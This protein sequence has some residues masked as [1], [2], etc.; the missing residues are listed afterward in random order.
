[1]T[2]PLFLRAFPLIFLGGSLLW[3]GSSK[4][5]GG[6]RIHLQIAGEIQRTSQSAT[7]VL[8]DPEEVITVSVI[9]NLS[10][11][12]VAS[13]EPLQNGESMGMIVTFNQLGKTLL[14]NLTLEGQ[15]RVMVIYLNDRIVYS[16]IIDSV[17]GNGVLVIPSG[18]TPK[19]LEML[20]SLVKKL[21]S[22]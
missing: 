15:G 17:I 22:R 2:F 19:D 7:V 5:S 21:K 11:T 14:N 8:E 20:Q 10:E 16:P 6:L 1:M 9:P 13:V 12:H 4:P 18:V 3:A